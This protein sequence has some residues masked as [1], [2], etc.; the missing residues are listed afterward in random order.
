[1]LKNKILPEDTLKCFSFRT[2]KDARKKGS[3]DFKA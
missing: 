2:K 1:M 3:I